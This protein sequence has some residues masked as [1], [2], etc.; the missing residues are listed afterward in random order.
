MAA[1]S[2]QGNM[3]KEY[4]KEAV[5][6][7]EQINDRHMKDCVSNQHGLKIFV[8]ECLLFTIFY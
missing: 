8:K 5:W 2:K 6:A 1:G 7:K 3:K 4:L